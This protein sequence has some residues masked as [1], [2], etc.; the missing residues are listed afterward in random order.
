MGYRQQF[1]GQA[2]TQSALQQRTSYDA[3]HDAY[4]SCLVP[5]SGELKSEERGVDVRVFV[6]RLRGKRLSGALWRRL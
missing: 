6:T 2:V 5:K 3:T 4:D 1:D